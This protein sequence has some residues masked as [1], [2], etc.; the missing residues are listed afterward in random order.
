MR[1]EFKRR[2]ERG[3]SLIAIIADSVPQAITFKSFD[4]DDEES[5]E[6]VAICCG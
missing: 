6:L 1:D 5:G 3:E 2:L 4:L